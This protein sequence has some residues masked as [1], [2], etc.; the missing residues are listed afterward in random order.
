MAVDS[1]LAWQGPYANRPEPVIIHAASWRGRPVLFEVQGSCHFECTP[2]ICTLLVPRHS[3]DWSSS[4][5]PLAFG[6]LGSPGCR[7]FN[8]RHSRLRPR[9]GDGNVGAPLRLCNLDSLCGYRTVGPA[10]L[11]GLSDFLDTRLPRSVEQSIG[12]VS[13]PCRL[14]ARHCRLLPVLWGAR[15]VLS[16][17]DHCGG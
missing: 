2:A 7:P 6:P 15:H 12:R 3:R 13:H 9:R 10:L 17:A 5:A 4:V 14:V 11:A 8:R 1:Q 16:I